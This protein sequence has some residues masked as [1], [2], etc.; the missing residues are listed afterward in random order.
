MSLGRFNWVIREILA[1]SPGKSPFVTKS[2][3]ELFSVATS[4]C[5]CYINMWNILQSNLTTLMDNLKKL[6]QWLDK[7]NKSNHQKIKT[8]FYIFETNI[9]FLHYTVWWRE[10]ISTSIKKQ[11][12]VVYV[13]LITNVRFSY[14][15]FGFQTR[16]ANNLCQQW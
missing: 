11:Q 10:I 6:K 15:H 16:K 2:L 12:V 7:L 14:L 4:V 1:V 13:T 3:F 9:L 5:Q 8:K